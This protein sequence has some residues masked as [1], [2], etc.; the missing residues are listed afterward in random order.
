MQQSLWNYNMRIGSHRV[1]KND[2]VHC[3][4]AWVRFAKVNK[5]YLKNTPRP[6]CV[7]LLS[8]SVKDSH[9][10]MNRLLVIAG[11]ALL[12]SAIM[13][14]AKNTRTLPA[15]TWGGEHVLLQIS[16]KGAEIEFDCARGRIVQ[17]IRLDPRGNFVVVGTFTP[18]HGGPV[19]RDEEEPAA[20]ASYSGHVSGD[21]MRLTVSRKGEKVVSFALARGQ[22]P[23]LRKC[24]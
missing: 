10:L 23:N 15:G 3:M 8:K 13:S 21:A 5:K 19:L 17:P 4:L 22:Q 1:L 7:F 24:R 6:A 11:C 16:G 2:K 12:G 14:A 9:M 20:Q 18:E